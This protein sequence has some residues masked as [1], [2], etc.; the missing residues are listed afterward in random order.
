MDHRE[1]APRV[2]AEAVAEVA[3]TTPLAQ[4]LTKEAAKKVEAAAREVERGVEVTAGGS[5]LVA[6][7][8]ARATRRSRSVPRISSTCCLVARSKRSLQ[9]VA[10]T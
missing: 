7:Q 2:T 10:M 5:S 9:A 8:K 6:V 4:L 3:P 1:A